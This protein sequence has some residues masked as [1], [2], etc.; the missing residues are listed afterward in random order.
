MHS[1]RYYRLHNGDEILFDLF[2]TITIDSTGTIS[3]LLK[4]LVILMVG[5]KL[6]TM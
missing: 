6:L 1:L 5:N 2:I 4:A 3:K